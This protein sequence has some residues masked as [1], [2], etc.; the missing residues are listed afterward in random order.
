ML[1]KLVVIHVLCPCDSLFTYLV[2]YLSRSIQY[3][4][5]FLCYLIIIGQASYDILSMVPWFVGLHN[6]MVFC[7]LT[8]IGQIGW[9]TRVENCI[10]ALSFVT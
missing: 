10:L 1:V 4:S 7:Y 5:I 3:L 2:L 8:T 6:M 9:N